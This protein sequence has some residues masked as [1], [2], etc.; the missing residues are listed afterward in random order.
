MEIKRTANAG[1][2]LKLDDVTV[3]LDGV[4]RQVLS[5]LPTP[6]ELVQEL[7]APWPDVVAFT[8]THEDHF[9]ESYADAYK[10]E[11]GRE[12]VQEGVTVGGVKLTGIPTRHMGKWGKS[13]PHRSFVVQGSQTVWFLG[14][15]SPVQIRALSDCPK[16]DVLIV[17]YPY[18]STPSVIQLL[19]TFLPCKIVLLHLPLKEKDPE[20]IWQIIAPGVAQLKQYLYLPQIGETIHFK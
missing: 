13:T 12:V 11:T 17:P 19:E 16:P 20:G 14:D 8:H 3:L 10:K 15:A 4:C 5:Y 7:S 6:P 2:L 18:V 9:D 1:V